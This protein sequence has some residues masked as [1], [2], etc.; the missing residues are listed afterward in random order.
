MRKH[1]KLVIFLSYNRT[2][3]TTGAATMYVPPPVTYPIPTAW[4]PQGFFWD[5][6]RTEHYHFYMKIENYP[7]HKYLTK[8]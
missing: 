1:G 7:H 4:S 8:I 5:L 3:R 2:A 6:L